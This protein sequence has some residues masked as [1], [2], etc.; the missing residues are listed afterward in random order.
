M[1]KIFLVG[2]FWFG[3]GLFGVP[4]FFFFSNY[5]SKEHFQANETPLLTKSKRHQLMESP[6][7]MQKT[8]IPFLNKTSTIN[9]P[10][11]KYLC[12]LL[13]CHRIFWGKY[14]KEIK[15]SMI[16][17]LGLSS[18]SLDSETSKPTKIL[19]NIMSPAQSQLSYWNI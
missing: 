1:P 18:T 17:S 19:W 11:C 3:V 7:M 9:T 8:Q 15:D 6:P 2:L 16:S 4:F 14:M 5:N 12:Y 13:I 10:N